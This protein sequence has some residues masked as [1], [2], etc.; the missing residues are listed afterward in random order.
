MSDA[1]I[2]LPAGSAFPT[3]GWP[4]VAGA[5]YTPASRDGW[6]M[7]VVYR[8][9]H[10][11]LCRKYLDE[12]QALLPRACALGVDVMAISAD[13]CERAAAQVQETGWEFPVACGLT[14]EQM[15]QLGLYVSAPRS[16]QETDRPF[17]EPALF[18][19]NP[20]ARL[21][22]ITVSNAPYSRPAL[23]QVFDGIEFVQSKDYPIRGMA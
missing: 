6:R 11:P 12:L 9:K 21:Q 14:V 1:S 16:P 18:V 19:I 3:M 20:Q 22:V 2:K 15:K 17:A 4:T 10:C 13:P 23:D 8:G 5:E 7:V